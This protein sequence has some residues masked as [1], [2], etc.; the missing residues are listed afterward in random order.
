MAKQTLIVGLGQFGS[1]LAQAMTQ[2]GSEVI[3]IDTNKQLVENI[4]PFVAEALVMD[5]M[6]EEALASLA[7]A[8]RDICICA[9]GEDNREASIIVTALLK[10]MGA[11]YIIAKATNSLHA[12]ILSMVG[13]NEVL[14]PERDYSER[15]AVRLAWRHVINVLPLDGNLVLTEIEAPESFWGQTLMDLSLPKRFS[16]IV[17]AIRQQTKDGAEASIPDPRKPLKRGDILMLVSTKENIR[18]FTERT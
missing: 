14:S 16:V 1:P 4:A 15:L 8:Q 17:S 12:R 7:P 9:I 11:P 2:H 3:A 18:L 5:A 10:Q 6:D 13:A